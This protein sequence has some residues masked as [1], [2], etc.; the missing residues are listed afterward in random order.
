VNPVR[1]EQEKGLGYLRAAGILDTDEEDAAHAASRRA[2]MRP[3]AL[4]T[5]R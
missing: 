1:C 5:S 3:N 4:G 2:A